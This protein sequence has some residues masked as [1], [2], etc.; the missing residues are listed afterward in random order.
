MSHQLVALLFDLGDT[1]MIEE[2]EVK[3]A[4][5]TTQR[6][7][8]IPGMAEALRRLKAQGHRLALVADT[9]PGTAVNVLR[10]HG[11]YD[12]FDALAISE[13]LGAEKPDPRMFE[14]ALEALGISKRDYH[15]VVMVG[16]HLEKDI[17]GA[18]RL[19]L[20]SVFLHWNERRRT[21][22]LNEDERP[23][24][25]VTS[26]QELMTLLAHLDIEPEGRQARC[27]HGYD[28]HHT[29]HPVPDRLG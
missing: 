14:A 24:Y 11:L 9:R 22:A 19:G 8:L 21:R 7:D 26:A 6:A 3:D 25:T 16:N 13:S 4:E 27:R 18:N 17:A 28:D 23:R 29:A 20:L 2:T 5:G 10:Q 15:R 12:L 1:I